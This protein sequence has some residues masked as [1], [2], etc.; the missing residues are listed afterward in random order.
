[1]SPVQISS[2]KTRCPPTIQLEYK[3]KLE[4]TAVY[5]LSK[6]TLLIDSLKICKNLIKLIERKIL[7]DSCVANKPA[8]WNPV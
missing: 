4:I 2:P 7:C 3:V 5:Q 8:G 6:C 1:M